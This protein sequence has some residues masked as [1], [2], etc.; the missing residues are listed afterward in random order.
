MSKSYYKRIKG[1]NYD[2]ELIELA[3][4]AVQGQGDGRISIQDARALLQAVQDAD[5]YTDI[6]KATMHYIRD[7]YD[8]TPAADKWFRQQIRSQAA[9][10]SAHSSKSKRASSDSA[11]KKMNTKKQSTRSASRSGSHASRVKSGEDTR[12]DIYHPG[13]AQSNWQ[14]GD[15]FAATGA[16]HLAEENKH[17]SSSGG[18]AW[19]KI[20]IVLLIIVLIFFFI[21]Q[22]ACSNGNASHQNAFDQNE[23]ALNQDATG[24]EHSA[25]MESVDSE[26]SDA[27]PSGN[28]Q[29][30]QNAAERNQSGT[31]LSEAERHAITQTR[32]PYPFNEARI[33]ASRLNATTQSLQQ[34]LSKH[35]DVHI[36]VVGHTCNIGTEAVNQR[37]S[38]ERAR[39]VRAYL[40]ER[41]IAADR[42]QVAGR[43]SEQ[44]AQ[45]NATLAGRQANRRV[46][47]EILR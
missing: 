12:S 6:E 35:A 9:R 46:T 8:F 24:P 31:E 32:V 16:G 37:K 20:A 43:G 29:S 2:R 14:T 47:F 45:D 3:D 19:W 38:L 10:R 11:G 34:I 30:A 5:D 4:Q 36:R 18:I 17:Q 41:G 40:I 25:V 44:P 13:G 33:P 23:A 21:R 28:E 7:H 22:Y 26:V 15:T 1:K 39:Q 27:H 42:L